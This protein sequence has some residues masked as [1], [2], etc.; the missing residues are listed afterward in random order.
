MINKKRM[1]ETFF[2]LLKQESPSLMELP[3]GK[4]LLEYFSLR[5]IEASMDDCGGKIGGDCGNVLVHVKGSMEGSAI[6]FA[7][8]MDQMY[9]CRDIKTMQR[10]DVIGTDGRTTLGGDDK[11]GIAAILEALEHITEE[12]IPH[13]EI[14]LLFTVCEETGL[15]GCRNFNTSLLPAKNIIVVDAAGPA[16]IIAWKAPAME[17]IDITFKGKK[18]HAGIEP[19]KGI[20][21]IK[22]AADA[23]SNMRIG[24]ID[25]ETTANIGRIEGGKATN[26]VTDEV[27][28]T[29]EIRSHS[30]KKL[31]VETDFMRRCCEDAAIKHAAKIEFV[32]N[33]DFPVMQSNPDSYLYKLC[34]RS[35]ENIGIKPEAKVIGGGSDA[36]ILCG[37]GYDCV[38]ISVGMDKVHTVEETININDMYNTA[39]AISEMM[40]ISE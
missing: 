28:L 12:N 20:N 38:I 29:A 34:E 3:M 14:Y 11:G 32:N 2:E 30:M 6:C 4:W 19:E 10:G 31:E 37:K 7:A 17:K 18:A 22:V 23:I 13:K 1:T 5:N 40:T 8:H 33:T 15:L 24:R 25:C 35:F 26:V 21:A 36:N 16:G 27:H 39:K 9:P